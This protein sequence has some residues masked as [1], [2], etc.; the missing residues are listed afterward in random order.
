MD[1]GNLKYIVAL[2]SGTLMTFASYDL[3][4]EYK[5]GFV[6]LQVQPGGLVNGTRVN[7]QVTD[8]AWHKGMGKS[9]PKPVG[10]FVGATGIQLF[11]STVDLHM[12]FVVHTD[13]FIAPRR[14]A[15][16]RLDAP[17]PP[18]TPRPPHPLIHAGSHRRDGG[19]QSSGQIRVVIT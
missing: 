14:T 18:L 15:L 9:E 13:A 17:E 8:V 6:R 7:F 3:A 11:E 2:D 19:G 5:C 12:S 4:D 16:R 10:T 1:D